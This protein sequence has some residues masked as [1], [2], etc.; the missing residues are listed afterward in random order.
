MEQSRKKQIALGHTSV[1]DAWFERVLK[2]CKNYMRKQ[3]N[4]SNGELQKQPGSE[5][6]SWGGSQTEVNSF[7]GEFSSDFG[8]STSEDEGEYLRDPWATDSRK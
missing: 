8:N 2:G 1:M 6:N 3:G 7:G 5:E 4:Y